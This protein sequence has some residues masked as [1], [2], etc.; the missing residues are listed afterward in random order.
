M[1]RRA[2]YNP[3]PLSSAETE[4]D[5][6]APAASGAVEE[7]AEPI[8]PLRRGYNSVDTSDGTSSGNAMAGGAG[9]SSE[10]LPV[11]LSSGDENSESSESAVP[12]A[13]IAD[14]ED[15]DQEDDGDRFNVV[16]LDSAQ[17]RFNV[18]AKETWTV[19][20]FKKAGAA[21]HKIAP[22][23]QRLIF[24]GRM[25]DD[26]STL[27]ECK[28]A[29][30]NVIV[31]LFPKPRVVV[32][33]SADD[34]PPSCGGDSGGG[35]HVPQIVLDE[36]EAERRGQILV[37]GSSEIAEAQNNVK[38]LSLLLLVV[39]SMRLLALFSIAMGVA[40]EPVNQNANH[41]VY[42]SD[43]AYNGS[44]PTD[45]PT[46]SPADYMTY[47]D[48]EYTTRPWET[49]DYFDLIVSGISFYV[50]TLGM[51]ATTENTLQLATQYLIGTI[52]A[53]VGFAIWNSY[54]YA[55]FIRNMETEVDQ[56]NST[57]PNSGEELT[58][59]DFVMFACFM[60]I[61]PAMV[62]ILCCFRAWQF[63]VLLAEAEQE[64]AERIRSQLSLDEEQNDD[65]ADADATRPIV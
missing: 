2:N 40:N 11:K 15:E 48:Q 20:K 9:E 34:G 54:M 45:P 41:P 5:D 16:V 35:A 64:A 62:W 52:V 42:L 27:A 28:I 3:V 6:A 38:L 19:A 58:A 24:R 21:I 65:S 53:G 12:D 7:E 44:L 25:L 43:D 50:A 17:S 55:L 60:V 26:E 13:L 36:E 10:L 8:R 46:M 33:S 61:I 29:Q 18:P 4:G 31:H 23:S 47:Q 56:H 14:S 63:R 1:P 37:L 49:K 59:G 39:C 51:K 57:Y 22:A 32:T 30:D